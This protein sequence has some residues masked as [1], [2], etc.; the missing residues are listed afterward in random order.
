MEGDQAETLRRERTQLNVFATIVHPTIP[1][2]EQSK[3]RLFEL[4]SQLI[5]PA[6][7]KTER[8]C[9]CRRGRFRFSRWTRS[10]YAKRT[11]LLSQH[12]G[13]FSLEAIYKLLAIHACELT[14][15]FKSK[16]VDSFS[17]STCYSG[18]AK[19]HCQTC[20]CIGGQDPLGDYISQ[21]CPH[22]WNKHADWQCKEGRGRAIAETPRCWARDFRQ[23]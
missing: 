1:R 16:V 19:C 13:S 9:S 12:Q 5:M 11:D 6:R 17:R 2:A 22:V 8:C 14:Q 23:G 20:S 10:L 15:P 4:I 18:N 7:S 3:T 21:L